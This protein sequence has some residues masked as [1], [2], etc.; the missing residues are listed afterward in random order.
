[1]N[2]QFVGDAAV[3]AAEIEEKVFNSTRSATVYQSVASNAIRVAGQAVDLPEVIRIALG[4]PK[5]LI[6]G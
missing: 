2:P 4:E 1:M 5:G 3:A 6:S